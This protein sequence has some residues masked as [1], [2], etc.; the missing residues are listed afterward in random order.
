MEKY[1]TILYLQFLV[2][3]G[4]KLNHLTW[5]GEVFSINT[6]SFFSGNF[7]F[8]ECNRCKLKKSVRVNSFFAGSKISL[9][10]QTHFLLK[11]SLKDSL[12]VMA[13]EGI[14]KRKALVKFARHCCK[15]AWQT[16]LLHSIPRL[17]GPGIIVQIDESKFN[18]K[19]K[20]SCK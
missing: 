16:L 18:H 1:C 9:Q 10:R 11:W 20:V 12:K 8:R 13:E 6:M 3:K 19:S 4:Q 2:I 14:A 17:R 15:I 7:R 5:N